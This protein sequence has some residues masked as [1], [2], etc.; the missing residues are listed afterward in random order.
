MS[1]YVGKDNSPMS[2]FTEG[3]IGSLPSW[4]WVAPRLAR[5]RACKVSLIGCKLFPAR[6]QAAGDWLHGRQTN[7]RQI[8]PRRHASCAGASQAARKY[9]FFTHRAS[10]ADRRRMHLGGLAQYLIQASNQ[11]LIASGEPGRGR[12]QPSNH[13]HR[14]NKKP[15]AKQRE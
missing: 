10:Q 4:A 9:W 14:Y 1:Q 5:P 7:S 13:A 8:R 12:T 11:R 2:K 15:V 6:L 3:L